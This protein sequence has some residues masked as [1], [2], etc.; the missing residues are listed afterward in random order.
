MIIKPIK[1][2]VFREN[3]DLI[4]FVKQHIKKLKEKSIL[5]IT[6]KIVALSQGRTVVAT[7]K[8]E[9]EAVTARESEVLIKT[10]LVNLTLKDGMLMAGAGID[11][12][13]GNGRLILLPRDSFRVANDLHLK[14]KK[15]YKV[16][17]LGILITDSRTFP[18]RAGVIGIATGF[19]GFEGVR[20]Y[21]GKPDIFGRKLKFSR[22]N[23]ADCLA[24]VAVL[25]MGEANETCPLAIIENAPITFTNK[26]T[27]KNALSIPIN[28]DMYKPLL[29]PLIKKIK[30]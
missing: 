14:L 24:T 21:R 26:R 2:R 12:S 7:T 3:E 10:K 11:A 4:V 15:I 29:M 9:K 25:L 22:T 27:R 8:R 16:K 30:K 20:D 13:N 1:T 18:L 23:N 17:E 28:D 6:S 19:A 5:V